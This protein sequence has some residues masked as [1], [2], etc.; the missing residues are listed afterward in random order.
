ME[1]QEI[2]ETRGEA[3]VATSQTVGIAVK[4]SRNSNPVVKWAIDKFAP[5]GKT[6][7]K[8]LHVLPKQKMVPTPS[9]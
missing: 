7:I 9:T 8:L 4:L 6:L 1:I 3:T 2:S 5:E